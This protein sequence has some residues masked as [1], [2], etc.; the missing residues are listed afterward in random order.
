MTL[1][2][3]Y[4]RATRWAALG[5][6]AL[7][8][9]CAAPPQD[10]N[11]LDVRFAGPCERLNVAWPASRIALH[12]VRCQGPY[13]RM[14]P[15]LYAY[16]AVSID[17]DSVP[18]VITGIP[19]DGWWAMTGLWADSETAALLTTM[20]YAVEAAEIRF[21]IDESGA[22]ST[23]D[24]GIE[25]ATGRFGFTAEASGAAEDLS[26][27]RAL[28]TDSDAATTAF[29]GPETAS[30]VALHDATVAHASLFET[31]RPVGQPARASLDRHHTSER[32]FWRLPK[33]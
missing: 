12:V 1:V 15:L 28:V 10:D 29:F 13:R 9:G 16:T 17:A 23:L 2:Y 7:L 5:G 19:D 27:R 33:Q 4:R 18:L 32:I 26:E 31:V 3:K 14:A 20:G 24:V 11:T 30:R 6:L 8:A 22:T 21:S 25:S